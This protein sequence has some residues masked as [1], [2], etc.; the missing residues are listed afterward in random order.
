HTASTP[1]SSPTAAVS[2]A[3]P[4][5]PLAGVLLVVIVVVAVGGLAYYRKCK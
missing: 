3:I 4:V 2:D 1:T 5:L